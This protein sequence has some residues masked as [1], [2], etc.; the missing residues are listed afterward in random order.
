MDTRFP[1]R[2]TELLQDYNGTYDDLAK[3]LGIKSKSNIT[4]YSNGSIKN[5][6]LSMIVKISNFFDVSPIWLIGWTDDK[7]FIIK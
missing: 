3:E 1:E 4:K 7:H 6:S 5:V 2:F